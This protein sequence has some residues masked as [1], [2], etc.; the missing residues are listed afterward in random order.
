MALKER[1]NGVIV[2]KVKGI[3]PINVNQSYDVAVAF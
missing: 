1:I 3:A 2:A